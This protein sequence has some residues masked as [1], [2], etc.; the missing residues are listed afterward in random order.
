MDLSTEQ[1]GEIAIALLSW[2]ASSPEYMGRFLALSGLDPEDLRREAGRREFH[3]ALLDH[4][5]AD[6]SLLLA[7]CAST[8]I[9]PAQIA[10][11]RNILSDEN[12]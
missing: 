2:M 9:P 7:F 11:A 10:P 5:L 3:I 6:E 4:A 8:N 12:R 1:A